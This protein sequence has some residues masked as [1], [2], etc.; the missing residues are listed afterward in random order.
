LDDQH[1]VIEDVKQKEKAEASK[2]DA[3][4]SMIYVKEIPDEQPGK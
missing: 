3:P 1:A 4:T 2:S